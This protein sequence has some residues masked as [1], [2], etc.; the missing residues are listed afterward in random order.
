MFRYLSL[1]NSSFVRTTLI[2]SFSFEISHMEYC[3]TTVSSIKNNLM[4]CSL[5]GI[6]GF[7]LFP[8]KIYE[9]DLLGSI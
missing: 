7:F 5:F 3:L 1:S 2:K 6:T 4:F 8:F 9:S